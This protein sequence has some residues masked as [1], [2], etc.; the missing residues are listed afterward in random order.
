MVEAARGKSGE[1]RE[2]L[3]LQ[4]WADKCT[5]ARDNNTTYCA[6]PRELPE[7]AGIVREVAKDV[8]DDFYRLDLRTG[9]KTFIASPA[10]DDVTAANLT[11]SQD[12]QNLFF[13]DTKTGTLK[14]MQ[15]K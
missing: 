12:G 7:G 14:K 5:I 11:L 6:V 13:T 9:T 3:G 10:G 15:L 8:P 2:Q 1:N 4:T